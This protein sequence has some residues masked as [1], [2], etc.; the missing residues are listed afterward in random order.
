MQLHEAKNKSVI[1]TKISNC[2]RDR[3]FTIKGRL[4]AYVTSVT[5]NNNYKYDI[6]R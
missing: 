1:Q 3:C 6:V 2:Q 4:I 5:D